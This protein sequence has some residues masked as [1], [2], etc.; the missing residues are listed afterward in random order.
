MDK[1]YIQGIAKYDIDDNYWY[2]VKCSNKIEGSY[3]EV[4]DW[5]ATPQKQESL[6]L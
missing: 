4:R 6:V 5:I 2:N 1:I 3:Q